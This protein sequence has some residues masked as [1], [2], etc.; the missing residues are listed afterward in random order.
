MNDI[1]SILLEFG[2]DLNKLT[3]EEIKQ[4]LEAISILETEKQKFIKLFPGKD[5]FAFDIFLCML[6]VKL[7]SWE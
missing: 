3:D 1:R 6:K 5:C 4:I 2:N 7:N